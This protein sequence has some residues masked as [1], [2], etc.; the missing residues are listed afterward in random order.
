MQSYFT[1]PVPSNL[2]G[3]LTALVGSSEIVAYL[4]DKKAVIAGGAVMHLLSG[5]EFGDDVDIW[6]SSE[7]YVDV[8][9]HVRNMDG[10]VDME[11]YASVYELHA[12]GSTLQFINLRTLLSYHSPE[13]IIDR[14]D[15]ACVQAAISW[16]EE[17]SLV[18]TVCQEF[19]DSVESGIIK[20]AK[21]RKNTPFRME[22][23]EMRG[24]TF[25]NKESI[26]D[27]CQ[28]IR[29]NA[30]WLVSGNIP[31]RTQDLMKISSMKLVH[32]DDIDLEYSS[33]NLFNNFHTSPFCEIKNPENNTLTVVL[34][35]DAEKP[36]RKNKELDV[37]YNAATIV[38][39]NGEEIHEQC[40]KE[41]LL[42]YTQVSVRGSWGIKS[43]WFAASTIWLK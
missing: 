43:W 5:R 27:R 11:G 17:G 38:I 41:L 37:V 31:E 25:L 6:L 14:F 8:V 18:V 36:F 12:G 9:D 15:F 16:N 33:M 40:S 32:C 1:V 22:K 29:K 10:V 35:D 28:A 21:I 24:F 23:Y 2:L 3:K 4:S 39:I 42:K 26:I 30:I 19:L 13:I 34:G 7:N 20:S